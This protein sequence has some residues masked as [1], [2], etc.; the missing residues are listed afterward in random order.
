MEVAAV[1]GQARE[2]LRHE[3][4][5]H[6]VLLGE[7]VH[8][9]AEEDRAVAADERVVV[10]E[11]LLELAV[12]VLVVVRVVAPARA[13]CST[14][15]PS[16]GSRTAASGPPCRSR[17][18]RACPER[19]RSRIDPSSC[20]CDEEVLELEPHLE[21]VARVPRARESTLR[22]IVRGQYG[23]GSPS[24]VTSQAKRARFGCHGTGVKLVEVGDRR[25]VR[26]ARDLSD[27]AGGEAGEAGTVRRRGRR[28]S[29]PG[30]ASR[31]DARTCRRT[32][33]RRTRSRAP[34]TSLRICSSVGPSRRHA[35]LLVWTAAVLSPLRGGSDGRIPPPS[36]ARIC[37]LAAGRSTGCGC[38][39]SAA[40]SLTIFTAI[41]TISQSSARRSSPESSAIRRSRCRSVFGCT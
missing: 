40:R 6:P 10:R 1:P 34:A 33:R 11:V 21:L 18:S 39:P 3:R 12:R 15:R 17:A 37:R 8:H 4:R 30:R 16:S 27:L 9:V 5:D 22:R 35:L 13:R 28:G 24:T 29:R 20:G 26:V 7:R 32:A 25:D 38:A 14:W 41:S 19:R 23:H 36:A 2:R 31:S